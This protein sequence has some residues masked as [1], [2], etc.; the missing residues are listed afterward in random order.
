MTNKDFYIVEKEAGA[1][2]ND[3]PLWASTKQNPAN[4]EVAQLDTSTNPQ[5]SIQMIEEVPGAFQILNVLSKSECESLISIA[6]SL[7]FN[8]DAAVSLPRHIRHNDSL[9]WVVDETTD[10]IIWQRCQSLLANGIEAISGLAPVGI[11]ARFRFY[12]YDKGDFF[13]P[14]TDGSWPGSRIIDGK[15]VHNAYPDRWSQMTFLILLSEDF[16][17]GET[18]FWVNKHDKTKPARTADDAQLINVRTP[19]GGV[20]C[21]PHGMHPMHCLH[22]SAQ[23]DEGVKYIIRT[24][25]LFPVN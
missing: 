22:S 6:E 8:K 2:S 15:N 4:L 16:K 5:P 7:G 13:K 24:D 21:F 25:L 14:H 23:I 17:G 3:I 19:A 12:K 9:T 20:L 10:S 11:N 1:E 18:Q